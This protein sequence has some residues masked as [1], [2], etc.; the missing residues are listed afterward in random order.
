GQSVEPCIELALAAEAARL[1]VQEYED[2][3]RDVFG[4]GDVLR[5]AQA[6]A[7]DA[8]VVESVN[9]LEGPRVSLRG[10]LRQS[11]I[12][13]AL[14]TGLTRRVADLASPELQV[15]FSRHFIFH[16]ARAGRVS[17]PTKKKEN[18]PTS[19]PLG[20]VTLVRE[21]TSRRD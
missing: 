4:L 14:R 15:L 13:L 9:L 1:P 16:V 21:M 6:Q 17:K 7:V 18:R 2:L 11:E 12:G 3:L 10:P 5:H 20:A 19:V 8:P